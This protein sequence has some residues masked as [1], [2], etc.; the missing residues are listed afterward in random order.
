MTTAVLRQLLRDRRGATAIEY[1]LILAMIS[2]VVIGAVSTT[3]TALY[4]QVGKIAN[5]LK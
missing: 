3:G 4:N 2:I 1:G 5:A